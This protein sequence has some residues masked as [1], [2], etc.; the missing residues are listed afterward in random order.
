MSNFTRV[1]LSGNKTY[2]DQDRACNNC[3]RVIMLNGKSLTPIYFVCKETHA[4]YCVTCAT[5]TKDVTEQYRE[6]YIGRIM[7][8]LT[9]P[10]MK[11]EDVQRVNAG[12]QQL[13][14]QELGS[15]YKLIW[16]SIASA[17][18]AN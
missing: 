7:D 3:G 5:A 8:E 10:D 4:P 18:D 6:W 17:Q 13:D 9:I 15:L 1:R 11:K 12:L 2:G 16:Q 14:V